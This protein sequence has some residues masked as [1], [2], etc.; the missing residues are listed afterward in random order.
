[1]YAR[2]KTYPVSQNYLKHISAYAA[3]PNRPHKKI[4]EKQKEGNKTISEN[5]TTARGI[6]EFT[7]LNESDSLV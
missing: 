1:M 4:G 3:K 2:K 7:I 6:R 5:R